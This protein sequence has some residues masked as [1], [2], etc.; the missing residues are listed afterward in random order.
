MLVIF[1]GGNTYT[2]TECKITDIL[3]MFIGIWSNFIKMSGVF[4]CLLNKS[5]ENKTLKRSK[6]DTLT[7]LMKNNTNK[8]LE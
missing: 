7:A 6:H 4:S 3:R 1:D 5:N 2:H 8:Y